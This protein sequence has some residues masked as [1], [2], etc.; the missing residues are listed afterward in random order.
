MVLYE[1]MSNELHVL[2]KYI[3]F[4][5][6]SRTFAKPMFSLSFY[7]FLIHV[8]KIPSDINPYRFNAIRKYLFLIH[9]TTESTSSSAE[10]MTCPTLIYFLLI[11]GFI[12]DSSII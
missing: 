10:N 7:P 4:Y 8:I 2:M 6:K 9:G 5:Q 1:Q 11:V 3:Y 12:V